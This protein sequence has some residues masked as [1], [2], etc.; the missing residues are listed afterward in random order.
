MSL[1]RTVEAGHEACSGA[2]TRQ[3]K[4]SS[5]RLARRCSSPNGVDFDVQPRKR[6][7]SA[8]SWDV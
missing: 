6:S 4:R 7:A 8:K 1:K 3:R 2:G 5:H